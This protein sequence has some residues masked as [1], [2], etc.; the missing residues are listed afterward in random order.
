MID[1][2]VKDEE[3]PVKSESIAKGLGSILT[4]EKTTET[5]LIE[6]LI[7]SSSQIKEEKEE[8][9]LEELTTIFD[10]QQPSTS[11]IT[12]TK[13]H[14]EPD[15]DIE[16]AAEM[17]AAAFPNR[18]P[19]DVLREHGITDLELVLDEESEEEEY[20]IECKNYKEFLGVLLD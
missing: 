5:Q 7:P 4:H 13:Q 10:Q 15:Y 3:K 8:N 9:K 12:T 1:G 20:E 6:E 14:L 2:K 17:F 16:A 19:K 11:T 18:E